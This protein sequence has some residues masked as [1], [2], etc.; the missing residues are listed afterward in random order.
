MHC[1]RQTS[2]PSATVGPGLPHDRLRPP[3]SPVRRSWAVSFL[4]GTSAVLTD[5]TLDDLGNFKKD[6]D[7]Q[8]VC[9]PWA[10]G[11]ALVFEVP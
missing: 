4:Y 11:Q 7:A 9:R 2:V 3:T 1:I 10:W 8:A 5:G 6:K